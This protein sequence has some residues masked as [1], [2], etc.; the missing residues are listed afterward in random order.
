M[1]VVAGVATAISY[2]PLASG[3]VSYTWTLAGTAGAADTANLVTAL[4]AT[5]VT[6][7]ASVTSNTDIAALTTL[8]NSLIAKINALN[9]L[10]IKIQKKVKA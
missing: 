2:A 3:P 9:K 7:S 8:V 10:V 1:A 5:T 4:Q 6:A